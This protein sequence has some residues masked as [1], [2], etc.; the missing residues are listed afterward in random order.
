MDLLSTK[1]M[2]FKGES[3]AAVKRRQERNRGLLHVAGRPGEVIEMSRDTK[4]VVAQD[5]SFRRMAPPAAPCQKLEK[6]A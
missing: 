4:Y 6:A 5:G 1:G 3:K 2:P